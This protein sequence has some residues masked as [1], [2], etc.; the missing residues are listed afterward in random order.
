MVT[1]SVEGL[2]I[3]YSADTF[4]VGASFEEV[5]MVQTD[6]DLNIEL[7]ASYTGIDN[8]SVGWLLHRQQQ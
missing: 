4:S 6:D 7:A 8:L 2:T 3:A 5:V 1:G